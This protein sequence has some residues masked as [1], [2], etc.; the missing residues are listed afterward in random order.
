MWNNIKGFG[1]KNMKLWIKKGGLD[2]VEHYQR[3]WNKKHE[4]VEIKKGDLGFFE[5]N[6]KW[7]R[8]GGLGFVEQY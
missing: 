8:K 6:K 3:L 1:T 5:Q 7:I 4:I 2:F